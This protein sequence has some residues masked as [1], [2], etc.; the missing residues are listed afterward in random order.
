[1]LIPTRNQRKKSLNQMFESS[2]HLYGFIL[3]EGHQNQKWEVLIHGYPWH[4]YAQII[5][6]IH[7]KKTHYPS[8]RTTDIRVLKSVSNKVYY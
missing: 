1:M 4:G 2:F 3:I 6:K 5:K 8:F 7:G